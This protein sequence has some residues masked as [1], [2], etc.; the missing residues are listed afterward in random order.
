MSFNADNRVQRHLTAFISRALLHLGA[1]SGVLKLEIKDKDENGRREFLREYLITP[2]KKADLLALEV[3]HDAQDEANGTG[4]GVHHFECR[5]IRSGEKT[6]FQS[7]SFLLTAEG[8]PEDTREQSSVKSFLAQ[9]Q[10]HLEAVMKIQAQE[11]AAAAH[12]TA[13][14]FQAMTEQ[15]QNFQNV[16]AQM[17]QAMQ[18]LA[19]DRAKV[20]FDLET[21]KMML[22]A[23]EKLAEVVAPIVAMKLQ[24][25]MFEKTSEEPL[26]IPEQ[27]ISVVA[28][29]PPTAPN[30]KAKRG[31]T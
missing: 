4:E 10:R 30:G 16:Q 7:T 20:E 19:V 28:D 13:S 26:Q 3:E 31:S 2:E 21:R 17:F 23:G 25:K 15:L 6:Q 29:S 22:K 1:E 5:A 14:M 9:N 12:S 27:A 24:E 18:T 11:R 8:V